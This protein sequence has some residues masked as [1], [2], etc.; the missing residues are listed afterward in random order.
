M[1]G[2]SYSSTAAYS[3]RIYVS[4]GLQNAHSFV[5]LAHDPGVLVSVEAGTNYA[6]TDRIKGTAYEANSSCYTGTATSP[7]FFCMTVGLKEKPASN[8]TQV[9]A[10]P[11]SG[12]PDG[13]T[14]YGVM[15]LSVMAAGV[16]AVIVRR[17][18]A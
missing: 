15:A 17:R 16:I 14:G 13:L 6:G 9:Y 1:G 4:E 3:Q 2:P 7:A 11:S 5:E 10:V 18:S 12:L 8:V